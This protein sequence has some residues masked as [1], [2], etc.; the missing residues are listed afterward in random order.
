MMMSFDQMDQRLKYRARDKTRATP[1]VLMSPSM[2]RQAA[3]KTIASVAS[4]LGA[5]RTA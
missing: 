1:E 5:C 2:F 4:P 3:I